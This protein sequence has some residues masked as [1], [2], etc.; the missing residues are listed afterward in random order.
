MPAFSD[1][2]I[3]HIDHATGL[4]SLN[5]TRKARLKVEKLTLPAIHFATYANLASDAIA[6]Q[7]S[8]ELAFS[9]QC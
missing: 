3:Q 1:V 7:Q 9:M 5:M 2:K 8:Q 6:P 4:L